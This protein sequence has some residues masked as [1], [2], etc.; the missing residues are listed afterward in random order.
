M[1]KVQKMKEMQDKLD[2]HFEQKMGYSVPKRDA[3]N[4]FAILDELGELNHELKSKWCWW[5]KSQKEVD[6]DKTIMELVDIYHFVLSITPKRMFETIDSEAIEK[7][8]DQKVSQDDIASFMFLF[9]NNIY[10]YT[11]YMYNDS[12]L[13]KAWVYLLKLTYGIGF[14][15]DDVFDAYEKKN[16]INHQRANSNY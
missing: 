6:Y 14:D 1:S 13:I 10:R 2:K 8:Y 16:K 3:R 7:K 4:F 9:I 15:F 12:A 11:S 5:K